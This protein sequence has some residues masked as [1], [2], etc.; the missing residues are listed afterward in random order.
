MAEEIW[1]AL[2]VSLDDMIK[3]AGRELGLRKAVYPKM[4]TMGRMTQASAD[5]EITRMEAVY[6]TLKKLQEGK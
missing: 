1:H 6:A 3:C 4:V 5:I 2:G